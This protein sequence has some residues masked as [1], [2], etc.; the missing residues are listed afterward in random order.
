[1]TACGGDDNPQIDANS[2]AVAAVDCASH[3]PTQTIMATGDETTGKFMPMTVTITHGQVVEFVT[4]AIHNVV[5]NTGTDP[6]LTVGFSATKCFQ[7]NMAG[8]YAFHCG[9]HGF[10]G[11]V[12]VN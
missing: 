7:F 10:Q 2:S 5:P 8:T 1:V 9:P 12:V 4:T 6:A 11:S 3:A